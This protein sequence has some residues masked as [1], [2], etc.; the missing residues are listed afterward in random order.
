MSVLAWLFLVIMAVA[1]AWITRRRKIPP[2]KLHGRIDA[3]V[4]A[5]NEEICV[6]DAIE[7]LLKNPYINRVIAVN[8]GSTDQ[9]GA[10][11]DLLGVKHPRLTIVHQANTGKGGALMNG[12]G[13]STAPYVFLT[14]A[15]TALHPDGDGLGYMI[16]EIKAGADAVGGIPLSNL[17][18]AGLLPHVRATTKMAII[19]VMRTF[20]QLIGGAPFL[21]SGACGLFKRSIFD[22]AQFSDRTKVEDLDLT[23]TLI[24]KGFK[25]RQANRCFVYSQEANNLKTEWLRWRRWVAGYGVCMRLHKGMMLSRFGLGTIIPVFLSSFVSIALAVLAVYT[26]CTD[27]NWQHLQV[28]LYSWSWLII[29]LM[30]GTVSAIHHRKPLLIPL[31]PAA[32][33]YVVMCYAVWVLYGL[34]AL[35]TGRE[36]VRDKPTRYANVVA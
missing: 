28:F 19:I 12:I 1:L 15:D 30:I 27:H 17:N 6:I 24:S 20:Q 35:F 36:P 2:Q 25:V 5:Y 4:P 23:W 10:I 22:Y 34:P 7:A 18:G 8:D 16:A 26:A 32:L 31:V 9:T 21:I 3:I 33:V 13:H 14:D 29:S 11:L